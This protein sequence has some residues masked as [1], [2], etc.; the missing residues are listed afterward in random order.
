VSQHPATGRPSL[1]I[2]RHACHIFGM[3]LVE[4]QSLLHDLL[5]GACQPPRVLTHRWTVGDVVI[6]DNR[7]ILHR[8]RPW[9]LTERRVLR[10]VRIAGD[11]EPDI[12]E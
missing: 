10:H 5:V 11:W 1:C 9:D 4:A 8:A 3:D 2:G 7:C 12:A 6:W